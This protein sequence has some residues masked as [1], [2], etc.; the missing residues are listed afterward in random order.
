MNYSKQ[1]ISEFGTKAGF[2]S[3]NIEMI[4]RL[5]MSYVSLAL[6]WI[7]SAKKLALK[8]GMAINLLYMGLPRLSVDIDLDYIGSLDKEE[9]IKDREIIM[10]SLES[11]EGYTVSAKSKGNCFRFWPK[12]I[13]LIWKGQRI[14]LRHGLKNSCR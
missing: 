8:G 12:G 2:I 9:A 14:K 7:Q 6:S 3:S 1:Y 5:L 10:N 11:K 4:I 13:D